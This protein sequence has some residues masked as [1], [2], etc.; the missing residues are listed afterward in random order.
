MTRHPPRLVI[1]KSKRQ[2][3][4]VQPDRS[5]LPTSPTIRQNRIGGPSMCQK[6]YLP[7]GPQMR[8]QGGRQYKGCTSGGG[9]HQRNP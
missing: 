4:N 6:P 8:P 7:C 5:K 1:T 2:H 9:T 3:G